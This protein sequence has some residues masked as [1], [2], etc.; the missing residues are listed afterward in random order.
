MLARDLTTQLGSKVVTT[1]LSLNCVAV[2]MLCLYQLRGLT[3][4]CCWWTSLLRWFGLMEGIDLCHWRHC[5]TW[6]RWQVM[7]QMMHRISVGGS[8]SC[9]LDLS[10]SVNSVSISSYQTTLEWQMTTFSVHQD[11]KVP[12]VMQKSYIMQ[13]LPFSSGGF[14][15]GLILSCDDEENW[16]E[17]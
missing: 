2:L 11:V 10:P 13:Y 14:L 8:W 1:F 4:P 5:P 6:K 17:R 3:N 9:I 15:T 16:C 12:Q 7:L